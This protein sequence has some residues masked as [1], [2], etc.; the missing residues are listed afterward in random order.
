MNSTDLEVRVDCHLF[1]L[2][3]AE[4]DESLPDAGRPSAWAG[5][6]ESALVFESEEDLVRARLRLELWD[7]PA[8]ID[9]EQWPRTTTAAWTLPSGVLGVDELTAGA[10]PEVFVVPP[11]EYAMRLGW[12][13]EG[14]ALVQMWPTRR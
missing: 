5:V 2:A 6:G 12:H 13:S 11:G 10:V 14:A 8:A 9:G 3:D 1:G 4:A 7:G